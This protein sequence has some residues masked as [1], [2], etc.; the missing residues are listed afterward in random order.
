MAGE[1]LMVNSYRENLQNENIVECLS[2][3]E[4]PLNVSSP[5]PG[6]RYL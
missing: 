3:F 6:S 2:G 1:N 4:E 5:P